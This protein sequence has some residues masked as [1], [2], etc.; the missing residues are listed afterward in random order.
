MKPLLLAAVKALAQAPDEQAA[1]V[2]GTSVDELALDLDAQPWHEESAD[3][4]AA[5]DELDAT[6]KSMSA[7]EHACLW[8]IDALHG[9]EWHQV[10]QVARRVLSLRGT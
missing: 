9:P 10:R 6:L 3:V 4:R 8:T 2:A 7:A 5:L 1:T